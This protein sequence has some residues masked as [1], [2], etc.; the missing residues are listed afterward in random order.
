METT[1]STSSAGALFSDAQPPN[2]YFP[3]A[4]PT[5][6]LPEPQ[7]GP[8]DSLLQSVRQRLL[9]VSASKKRDTTTTAAAAAAASS[10]N[11]NATVRARVYQVVHQEEEE[12]A[13]VDVKQKENQL[14]RLRIER[15]PSV[16]IASATGA[17]NQRI[18][19][20]GSVVYDV[21]AT[22][23]APLS[24]LRHT[25]VQ[26]VASEPEESET[27][28]ETESIQ[29]D[30][31]N[32]QRP[33]SVRPDDVAR[34]VADILGDQFDAAISALA[35]TNLTFSRKHAGTV[36]GETTSRPTVRCRSSSSSTLNCE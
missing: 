32:V 24:T 26:T 30:E 21:V 6:R 36:S 22:G 2:N 33:F 18:R 14:Q 16:T 10:N 12:E 9:A 28:A 29:R 34:A 25:A 13:S 27:D 17:Y 19:S 1:T 31:V 35:S 7:T 8:R 3:H 20:S 15:L 23:D 4:L 5:C 11:N